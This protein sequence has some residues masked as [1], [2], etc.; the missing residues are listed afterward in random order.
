M[1]LSKN[2]VAPFNTIG[3]GKI[4]N[5]FRAPQFEEPP[6]FRCFPWSLGFQ[7]PA[8]WQPRLPRGSQH[9]P[10]GCAGRRKGRHQEKRKI[11]QEFMGMQSAKLDSSGVKSDSTWFNRLSTFRAGEKKFHPA[12]TLLGRNPQALTILLARWSLSAPPA[13]ECLATL[14]LQPR[15]LKLPGTMRRN[16]HKKKEGKDWGSWR[17][18]NKKSTVSAH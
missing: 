13:W 14:T 18:A 4:I 17:C 1:V 12:T 3:F 5:N 11:D 7:T 15:Q 9:R 6:I 8:S 2:W 16:H 10:T